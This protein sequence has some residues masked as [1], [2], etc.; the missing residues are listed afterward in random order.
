MLLSKFAC[1]SLSYAYSHLDHPIENGFGKPG[2]LGC[3]EVEYKSCTDGV[4]VVDLTA[5][6]LFEIEVI[7]QLTFS[8]KARCGWSVSE[9]HLTA[10]SV[11]IESC[12]CY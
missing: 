6:G 3:T 10:R 12:V 5:F 4:A 11:M 1:I 2:W 9:S 8:Y 7:L